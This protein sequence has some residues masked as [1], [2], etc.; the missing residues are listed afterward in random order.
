MSRQCVPVVGGPALVAARQPQQGDRVER[1]VLAPVLAQQGSRPAQ[2]GRVDADPSIPGV[3]QPRP[4][5]LDARELDVGDRGV[6]DHR[7]PVDE[8]LDPEPLVPVVDRCWRRAP[9]HTHLGADEMF[10]SEQRDAEARQL[11]R[12]DVEEVVG[13]G[14]VELDPG[15][16]VLGG[17]VGEAGDVLSDSAGEVAD[18]QLHAWEMAFVASQ[19]EGDAGPVPDVVGGA[20]PAGVELVVHLERDFPRI[21]GVLG[22]RQPE[23]RREHGPT[24]EALAVA[25]EQPAH[26]IELTLELAG[27]TADDGVGAASDVNTARSTCTWAER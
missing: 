20:P 24:G 11:V 4:G 22:D 27:A 7:R 8:R 18:E 10:G 15:R 9:A 17:Q 19:V 12:G 14:E 2:P 26:R 3:Q 25:V 23:T 13:R 1:R 6:V 5:R 16:L 21:A